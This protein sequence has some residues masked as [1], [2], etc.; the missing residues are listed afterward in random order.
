[1]V[2]EIPDLQTKKVSEV[3]PNLKQRPLCLGRQHGSEAGWA[4]TQAVE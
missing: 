1:M 4:K 3:P 2:E